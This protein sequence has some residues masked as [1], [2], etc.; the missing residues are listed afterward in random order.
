MWGRVCELNTA[1]DG[2]GEKEGTIN[3]PHSEAGLGM[4]NKVGTQSTFVVFLR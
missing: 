1:G 4:E 2:E 3:S